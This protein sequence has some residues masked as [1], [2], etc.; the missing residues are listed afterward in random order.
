[1]SGSILQQNADLKL[2]PSTAFKPPELHKMGIGVVSMLATRRSLTEP[3]SK[4]GSV[5]I[6]S[7]L[8]A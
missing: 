8:R 6:R 1:M 7:V 5:L 2:V 4:L 3:I